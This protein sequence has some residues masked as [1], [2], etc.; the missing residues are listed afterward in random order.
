MLSG[1]SFSDAIK[2]NFSSRLKYLQKINHI[3]GSLESGSNR[4]LKLMNKG[5]TREEFLQMTDTQLTE[6]V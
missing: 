5:F 4:I 2:N 1:F 6:E 3:N